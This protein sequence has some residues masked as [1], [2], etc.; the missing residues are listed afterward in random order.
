VI[1]ASYRYETP[2]E[3]NINTRFLNS[4]GRSDRFPFFFVFSSLSDES[5]ESARRVV[6]LSS[7]SSGSAERMADLY[8]DAILFEDWWLANQI[9]QL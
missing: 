9:S 5:E 2:R 7:E 6:L 3:V 8:A 1:G 4:N